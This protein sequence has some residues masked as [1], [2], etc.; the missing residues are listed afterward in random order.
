MTNTIWW[1]DFPR[2]MSADFASLFPKIDDGEIHRDSKCDFAAQL[3]GFMA[4]LVIDVPSQ[5]HWITQLTTYDFGGATG[6][7]VASVPGIHF[8][9]T[10]VMSESLQAS[11]V[12]TQICHAYV[13]T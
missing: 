1:Q 10:S 3:A 8:Y 9:R 13:T 5:T 4:S 6:H 7:L 11:P 2:A 12:S